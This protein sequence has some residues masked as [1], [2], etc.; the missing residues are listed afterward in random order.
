MPE[1]DRL[2]VELA[3]HPGWAVLEERVR[4]HQQREAEQLALEL[5]RLKGPVD[6]AEIARTRGFWAG[7]RW[8]LRQAKLEL[9]L[10]RREAEK[11]KEG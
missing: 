6:Q 9:T 11:A 10:F 4:E 7:Q 3:N 2:L 1:P 5:L 8:L